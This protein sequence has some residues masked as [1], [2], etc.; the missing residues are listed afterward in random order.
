MGPLW[1]FLVA[2]DEGLVDAATLLVDLFPDEAQ[3]AVVRPRVGPPVSRPNRVRPEIF[4]SSAISSGRRG[5]FRLAKQC[6]Q[7]MECNNI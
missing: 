5:V 7:V 3:V 1:Q 2:R 6:L 4:T